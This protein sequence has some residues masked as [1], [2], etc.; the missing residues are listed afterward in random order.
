[1]NNSSRRNDLNAYLNDDAENSIDKKPQD[2]LWGFKFNSSVSS[3]KQLCDYFIAISSS[4][5]NIINNY[6]FAGGCSC[7]TK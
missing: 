3:Y 6:I 1:M 4:E 7:Q 2:Y 5:L